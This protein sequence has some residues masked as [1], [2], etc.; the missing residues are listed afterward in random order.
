MTPCH[1]P[2]SA[3]T[4]KPP[5]WSLAILIAAS[6]LS[7]PVFTKSDFESG[8]GTSFASA[9][10]SWATLRGIIP[11]KRWSAVSQLL[12]MAATMLGW[13]CPTVAHIWPE[14]KSRIFLP[15]ASQT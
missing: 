6:L 15:E 10:E 5:L 11:E 9:F 4:S 14:V 1:E 3:T 2:P 7:L 13:L 8:R 12:R